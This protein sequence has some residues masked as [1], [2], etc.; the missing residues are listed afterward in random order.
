MLLLEVR[1]Y[2]SFRAIFTVCKYTVVVL[3]VVSGWISNLT[4]LVVWRLDYVTEEG[5]P[6]V[7]GIL[8]LW[9]Q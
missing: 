6:K 3:C 7:I 4:V 9:V 2:P 5:T 1:K 8:T